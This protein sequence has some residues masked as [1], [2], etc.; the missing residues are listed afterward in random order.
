MRLKW[1]CLS[2][3]AEEETGC[4]GTGE[5][6]KRPAENSASCDCRGPPL[7]SRR[8]LATMGGYDPLRKHLIGS[9]E[10]VGAWGP[11]RGNPPRGCMGLLCLV[12]A[13]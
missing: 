11:S 6:R 13:P 5:G 4:L 10:P 7:P 8:A 12:V 3:A 9:L 2:G 1:T